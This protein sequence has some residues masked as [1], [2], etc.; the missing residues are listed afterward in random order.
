MGAY[1]AW[2]AGAG[3]P[4]NE[5]QNPTKTTIADKSGYATRREASSAANAGGRMG[6]A[7]NP[8]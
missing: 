6:D 2:T 8:S 7:D 1:V 5:Q 3:G 4:D